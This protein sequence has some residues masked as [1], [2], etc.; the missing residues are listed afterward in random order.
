[1]QLRRPPSTQSI[2]VNR[3]GSRC[4]GIKKQLRNMSHIPH[5]PF[6]IKSQFNGRV[7]DVEGGSVDDNAHIIVW[8]Q[9][10]DKAANQ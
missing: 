5:G 4:F 1:M 3:F 9:K 7:I 8:D 10:S 2:N 6:Y